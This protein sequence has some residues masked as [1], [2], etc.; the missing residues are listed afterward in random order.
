MKRF[1][2]VLLAAAVVV[3]AY[4]CGETEPPPNRP[5]LAAGSIPAQEL[6]ALD[7]VRV[8]VSQYFTDEDGDQLTYSAT[9]TAPVV[10]SASMTGPVLSIVGRTAGQGEVT[11]TARDPDGLSATQQVSVTVL[12]RPGFLS[13]ELRYDEAEI[14]AVVVRLEGPPADSIQAPAGF[15]VYHAAAAGGIRAFVAGAI[16][17]TGTVLRFWA[18]DVSSPGAYRGH[19]EQA[20][21]T[22]YR[23]RPVETGTV[24]IVR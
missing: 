6:S 7:T 23:Q 1:T 14:G 17:E 15:T 13:V 4:S 9:S 3:V 8:D 24:R 19:L 16:P 5:P 20:A 11:V 12:G 18:E 22:D 21:G 10:V 2:L